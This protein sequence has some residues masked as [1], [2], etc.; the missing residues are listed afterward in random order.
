MGLE[1][2]EQFRRRVKISLVNRNMSVTALAK[3]I[4]R[5]RDT[6]STAINSG[7]FPRVRSKIAAYLEAHPSHE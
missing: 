2:Q 1:P 5:R 7:R 3:A 4:A 6:V